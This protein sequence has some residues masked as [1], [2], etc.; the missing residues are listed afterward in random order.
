VQRTA[1]LVKKTVTLVPVI[2]PLPPA[3]SEAL[4]KAGN[5]H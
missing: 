2:P 1:E 3:L 5:S 4:A